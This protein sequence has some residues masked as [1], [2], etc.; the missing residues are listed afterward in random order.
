MRYIE[1]IDD[2]LHDFLMGRFIEDLGL[3]KEVYDDDAMMSD[4]WDKIEWD[5]PSEKHIKDFLKLE[6]KLYEDEGYYPIWNEEYGLMYRLSEE[7]YDDDELSFLD[8]T[9]LK[10]LLEKDSNKIPPKIKK[11]FKLATQTV[12]KAGKIPT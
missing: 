7:S 1:Y 11:A 9:I 5:K 3:G 4:L 8:R 2:E 6:I 12:R 10:E